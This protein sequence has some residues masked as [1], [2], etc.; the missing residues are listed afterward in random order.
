MKSLQ[1]EVSNIMLF[2]FQKKLMHIAKK[3]RNRLFGSYDCDVEL[4]VKQG[5]KIG[6]NV[7]IQPMVIIDPCHCWL[8]EI[9]DD[10][11]IA[12]RAY[13]LAHDAS[14]IH[15]EATRIGC[16]YI[17]KRT[18]IG[19]G[20]IILPGV[21]IG[22][23]CLIGAGAVV[24]GSIPDNSVVVGN[25]GKIVGLR[26]DYEEKDRELL[27]VLPKFRFKEYSLQGGITE[28]QKV[29]MKKQLKDKCGYL[30]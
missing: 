4:L 9:D 16:V 17:G 6:K 24:R 26:T 14:S 15:R 10:V 29:E 30:V 7:S 22:K 2:N 8:I 1:R 28:E 27:K 5:L 3:I 20:A 18:F 12:P 21:S 23:N 19:A 13:I 11:T 25:P